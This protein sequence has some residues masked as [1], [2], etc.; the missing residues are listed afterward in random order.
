MT[1][2]LGK[3][4]LSVFNEPGSQSSW[5]SQIIIHHDWKPDYQKFDADIA[6][7]VLGE[8]L[9]FTE[10]IKPISLPSQTEDNIIESGAILG[11]MKETPIELD[12]PVVEIN[13]CYPR[14]PRLADRDYPHMFCAGYDSENN[15][16]GPDSLSA[17]FYASESS[18]SPLISVEGIVSSSI[19]A[20]QTCDVNK[21]S[22]YTTVGM[23]VDWIKDKM[24]E[25]KENQRAEVKLK[26]EEYKR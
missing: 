19:V 15:N 3:F 14:F 7:V 11:W 4:N 25:T 18:S 16:A 26:C 12:M 22:L 13:K 5:V 8:E 20:N 9:E 17:G 24:K 23:F 10:F 21:Y 1:A 6:V 2:H